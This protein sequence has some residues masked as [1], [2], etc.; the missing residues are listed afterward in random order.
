VFCWPEALRQFSSLGLRIELAN[1]SAWLAVVALGC[2]SRGIPP[3]VPPAGVPRREVLF[4]PGA[5]DPVRKAKLLAVAP[6]LD[7]LFRNKVREAGATGLAVGIVLDGELVYARG[8]GV[9]DV[10]S[11]APVDVDTVFRIAS[12]TK[13]FTAAAVLRLRDE[14][15]LALDAP[16]ARY[17]PELDA[18]VVPTRDSPP[19]TVRQLLTHG[20]GLP[21]DDYWGAETFGTGDDELARFLRSGIAFADAPGARYAYS[22]LGYALLGK[23]VQRVSGVRFRDYV[24]TMILRPLGMPS[25]VWESAEVP[26]G[27]LAIGYRRATNVLAP[28]PRPSDGVFDAAGGLYTSLRDY[29]RYV[30]FQLAAYPPRDDP[31]AGPLRRSTL[32]EMHE[33]QR[34]SRWRGDDVP[35]ARRTPDN[36]IWLSAANYGFGWLNDTTCVDEGIVQHGGFEPGYWSTVHLLPRRGLGIVTLATSAPIGFASFTP[37]ISILREAGALP[38]PRET[39]VPAALSSALESLRSLLDR[40]DSALYERT[41]DRQSLGFSWMANVR[42]DFARLSREHGPC[43]PEASVEAHNRSDGSLRLRCKRGAIELRALLT[44]SAP[45]RVQM[46]WWRDTHDPNDR[47]RATR[48]ASMLGD[49]PA[50]ADLFDTTAEG[51]AARKSFARLSVDHGLCGIDRVVSSDGHSTASF[52]FRCKERSFDLFFRVDEH[53]GRVTEVRADTPHEASAPPCEP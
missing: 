19:V 43:R 9:R 6:Q 35:V 4:A 10:A 47:L 32:R 51:G 13:S 17:A 1:V 5:A 14:G 30:A 7:E 12:M 26:A 22:N 50:G 21:L 52:R 31:E 15:R 44:P 29:A 37:A 42:E 41:F 20:A 24:T 39:S 33:G 38:P 34:W 40:W 23:I 8:F 53:S 48:L 27:R 3:T 11:N 49:G 28:E 16:A 36:G 25:T 2:V 46:L 18:L 45:V